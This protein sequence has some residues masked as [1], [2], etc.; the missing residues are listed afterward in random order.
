TLNGTTALTPVIQDINISYE[1]QKSDSITLDTSAPATVVELD[2]KTSVG[3]TDNT[4]ATEIANDAW[5]QDLTPYFSWKAN[6]DADLDGAAP[7]KVYFGTNAS[8]TA[9][10]DGS[11]QVATTYDP[12]TLTSGNQYYLKIIAKDLAGNYSAASKDYTIKV[13]NTGANYTGLAPTVSTTY[14]NKVQANWAAPPDDSDSIVGGGIDKY[15]VYWASRDVGTGDPVPSAGN[16]NDANRYTQYE[17]PD[18]IADITN[19]GFNH[20]SADGSLTYYYKIKAIDKAGNESNL[21]DMSPAGYVQDT[22]PPSAT[23]VPSVTAGTFDSGTKVQNVLNWTIASDN[24]GVSGYQIYRSKNSLSTMPLA[25]DT[26]YTLID[27][28]GTNSYTD[29]DGGAG[30]P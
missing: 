22:T 25:G 20:Y 28:V 2:G 6:A 24:S 23:G 19:T 13:D 15:Y 11:A 16:F 8:A 27:T 5:T 12:G 21:S 17:S 7:Y 4:V 1:I 9:A 10:I 3:F 29:N 14:S 26:E 30:R 18:T